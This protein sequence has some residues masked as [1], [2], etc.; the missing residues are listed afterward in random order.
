MTPDRR[1]AS[2]LIK[3]LSRF[4]W[5]FLAPILAFVALGAWAFASPIGAG[6]D[7]DYH[8]VS[9]WCANGGSDQ[10]EPG[11]EENSRI[12]PS[13]F[14][15]LT[16]YVQVE[17]RSAACQDSVWPT[18]DG[19]PWETTRG[20]FGGEYPPVYYATMR[21]FA[22]GDIQTSALVMRLINAAL[23]V[24]LATALAV[25]LP[26]ARRRTL[27]WGWLVTLVPLG[28]FL[29][30]SNNPSGWA[31]TG[32]GTAF[33]ALLG[34]FETDGR[35]RWALGALYLV[36]L[37]MAAGA[38]GD[39]AVYAV[40]ATVTVLLLTAVRTRAW[41]FSA[42]LPAAGL[43]VALVLFASAGQAGVG[44]SGF[45]GGGTATMPLEGDGGDE[46]PLSG[47]A[48]A[49]YNLL[50][51]PFLW[52]GVWGTW[53]LGWF[54]TQLPAIVPWSATAAF[55][56]VAFAGLGLL[57]WRKAIAT[58]GV[59]FVLV[60]LPTYVLTVG[61]DKVG[62]QLQPRYLLPLIVLF[63]F[64]LLTE[65]VQ[66]RLRFT[67]VQTFAIL[68]ALAIANFVA[69]QV[70]IRRY[71]TGADEQGLNLDVGA[72][73]WWTGFPLGPSAVWIVG[74]VA[75]A[76]L[77]AILWPRLRATDELARRG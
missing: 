54:D 9:I 35:R 40:G 34:W 63:A 8:L 24:G 53:G 62:A 2:R 49:A 44:A 64:L 18:W 50:M 42:I 5:I 45:S 69:L 21:L 68:G 73:W 65:T 52:T 70:N 10:C 32:I 66:G 71:V 11:T 31:I 17:E 76:G 14:R 13:A 51:L 46:M 4:R 6:P 38:R 59:L 48:L 25:L 72:E 58:S 7:D 60:A 27:L 61:G 33:L 55:I 74:A 36:G 29:I 28:M 56:V 12:V 3:P 16:C 75:Y 67:R 57:T 1:S 23:F 20:N 22:G 26:D 30:P 77:L 15:E 19:D 41:A 47:F 39:A 37:V 43:V